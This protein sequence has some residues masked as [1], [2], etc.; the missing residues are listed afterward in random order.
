MCPKVTYFVSPARLTS[1]LTYSKTVW[2][3]TDALKAFQHTPSCDAFLQALGCE[4]KGESLLSLRWDSGFF[5]GDGPGSRDDLHGR[6]TLTILNIPYIGIPDRNAWG[7]AIFAAFG[8]FMPEGCDDLRGPPVFQW[9]AYTWV[10]TVQEEQT[11]ALQ[12]GQGQAACYLFFRWNGNGA[13]P[14]REEASAKD[15]AARESW[16]RA[17][18][19]AM[20]PVGSWDQER[21][22]IEVAPCC[23]Y[24][25]DTD[26]D[27]DDD[28]GD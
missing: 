20:P 24:L 11:T 23:I 26:E 19:K 12:T 14:A 5:L 6:I 9:N 21:W 2:E 8:V 1:L 7:H 3:S 22:D 28:A 25:D 4:N 16:A 15:P 13:S 18:A 10:D 17:V 27:G